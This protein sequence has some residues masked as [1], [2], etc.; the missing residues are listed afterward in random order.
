M[1]VTNDPGI[2]FVPQDMSREPGDPAA[3]E[4]A[5]TERT[6]AP[7]DGETV[8]LDVRNLGPPKPLRET[9]ER[10]EALGDGDVLVQY[11]DR[12]PQFLFP[13][14]ADRGYAY[15]A[16]E[17]D[18]TDAVVTAVWPADDGD[19]VST[20]EGTPAGDPGATDPSPGSASNP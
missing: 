18:A 7:T 4:R 17:T 1:F 16:V 2:R 14:L 20:D 19:G 10:V 6:D 12:T 11:N 8:S 15:A 5:V 13:R 3:V 9:L